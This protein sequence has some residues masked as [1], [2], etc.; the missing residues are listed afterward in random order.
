MKRMAYPLTNDA[1]ELKEI[2]RELRID[3]LKMLNRAKS[4]H[5]GGSLSAIDIITCLYFSRLRHDPADPEWE[6]RDIFF[7]SKGHGCPA[8]YAALARTGYFPKEAL[9]KLR[10]ADGILSGHPDRKLTPGVE[11][12]TGSL[13]H[14]I[15][16]AV[17]MAMAD[18]LD[19]KTR[20]IFCMLGDGEMQ[21]GQVWEAL[22]C[23]AHHGLDRL[24]AILDHNEIETDGYCRDIMN[25]DPV[26]RK[27]EGFGWRV[28]EIDGHDFPQILKAIDTAGTVPGKPTFIWAHTVKGK[29]VSF[30]EGQAKYHGVAPTDEELEKALLEL[31]PAGKPV[32]T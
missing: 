23:G 13:G 18:K 11:A 15:S 7:L 10:R 24:T 12:S 1:E 25:I 16:I 30:M 20:R 31:Q 3:I 22:M 4:G 5:S 8:Q 21:E 29:G 32:H 26:G 27:L 6:D 9:K 14:G 19:K 17:G 28:V 2:A